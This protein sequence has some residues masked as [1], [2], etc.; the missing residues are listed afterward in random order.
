[1]KDHQALTKEKFPYIIHFRHLA[2]DEAWNYLSYMAK[3]DGY[4][5]GK[6]VK[7]K[8]RD[9]LNNPVFGNANSLRSILE[10]GKMNMAIRIAQSRTTLSD[11]TLSTLR[12]QDFEDLKE[13]L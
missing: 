9:V 6:G 7:E 5:L 10:R 3:E 8:L 2:F 13:G 11:K 12:P 1:M 4:I